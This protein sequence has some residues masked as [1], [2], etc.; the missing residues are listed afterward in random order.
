MTLVQN[1][2]EITTLKLFEVKCWHLKNGVFIYV[3]VH[4]YTQYTYELT[5]SLIS[6]APLNNLGQESK[7]WEGDRKFSRVFF[8]LN[9]RQSG[10]M[11]PMICQ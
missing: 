5:P 1:F 9:G 4:T 11:N 6:Q 8:F 10:K 3:R 2:V 7:N